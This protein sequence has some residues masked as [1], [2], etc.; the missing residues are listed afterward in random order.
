MLIRHFYTSM[1]L[2]SQ[3]GNILFPV[4][5]KKVEAVAQVDKARAAGL[6]PNLGLLDYVR[7]PAERDACLPCI[8]LM[9]E[10]TEALLPELDTP[11][12]PG[13]RILFCGQRHAHL[14]QAVALANINQLDYLLTG[15]DSPGG[16]FW[17]WLGRHRAVRL[18]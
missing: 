5:A 11:I 17:Q 13:D 16:W 9:L 7:D 2:R 12:F 4:K 18:P 15:N 6:D 10:T 14:S 3:D 1:Q 8:P